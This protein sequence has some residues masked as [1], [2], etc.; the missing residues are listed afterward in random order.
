MQVSELAEVE[1]EAWNKPKQSKKVKVKSEEAAP[2][3]S[4]SK[5]KA[6]KASEAPDPPVAKKKRRK[7]IK[8]DSVDT[9]PTVTKKKLSKKIK[10]APEEQKDPPIKA[11]WV[12]QFLGRFEK[13]CAGHFKIDSTPETLTDGSPAL[14]EAKKERHRGHE[15]PGSLQDQSEGWANSYVSKLGTEY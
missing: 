10:K 5:P 11:G 8:E 7:E 4:V 14:G 6:K 13:A 9:V 1:E 2:A 15:S 12:L 3:V